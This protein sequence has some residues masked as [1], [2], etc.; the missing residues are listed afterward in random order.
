LAQAQ[1]LQN[2]GQYEKALHF[3][4]KAGDLA[5]NG[6]TWARMGYCLCHINHFE[7]AAWC[8][9]QAV[10]AGQTSA[11]VWNNWGLSLVEGKKQSLDR[12]LPRAYVAF[13]QAI[14]IDPDATAARY[15]RALLC[16]D[17]E[18][19]RLGWRRPPGVPDESTAVAQGLADI[20]RALESAP[21]SA[22]LWFTAAR[23]AARCARRRQTLTTFPLSPDPMNTGVTLA[24]AGAVPPPDDPMTFLEQAVRLGKDPQEFKSDLALTSALKDNLRFVELTHSEVAPGTATAPPDRLIDPH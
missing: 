8:H 9:E 22:E 10:A 6:P 4:E 12:W 15:N 11:A 23:L 5:A 2:S 19:R 24:A 20:R 1:Q 16:L 13:C 7:Q 3:Y 14:A 18:R 21:Q 17:I